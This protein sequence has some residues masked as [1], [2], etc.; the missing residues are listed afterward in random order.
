MDWVAGD[1]T[2]LLRENT[3]F[4]FAGS[5]SKRTIDRITTLT[6][7]DKEVVFR[8]NK[9]G[10]LGMRMTRALEQPAEKP[11]IFTDA[12]GKATKVPVLDNKGVTGMYVSS[13]GIKGDAVWSTRGR[14]TL[15]GGTIDAQPVT[16]AIL[17]HPKNPGFPTH[18]HA[19][20]Y[21]LFAANMLGA[22]VF[23]NGKEELNLTLQPGKSVTFRHRVVILNAETKPEAIEA[24]YKSFTA[25]S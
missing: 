21:G 16:V 10:V 25:G 18:W 5:G 15:L 23:S 9:E 24:E 20:G 2:T 17:D 3:T 13:E 7:L 22:K 11:E 12:S 1:G 19:R 4:V 14:W 8:D 6:A